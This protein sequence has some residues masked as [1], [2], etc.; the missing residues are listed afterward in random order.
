VAEAGIRAM[1]PKRSPHVTDILFAL[2]AAG[3]LLGLPALT[4]LLGVY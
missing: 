1:E 2:L 3:V 4:W